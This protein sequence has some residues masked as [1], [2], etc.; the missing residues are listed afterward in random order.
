MLVAA[1]A[2]TAALA[3]GAA[4]AF[5]GGRVESPSSSGVP[6]AVGPVAASGLP[7]GAGDPRA[8]APSGA[9]ASASSAPATPRPT[10]PAV[11]LPALLGAIGD[12]LTAAVNVTGVLAT[13]PEHSWVLGSAPDDEVTSHL[14]RLRTLGSDPVVVPAARPGAPIAAAVRQANAIVERAAELEDGATAYVTFELG[15]NDICADSLDET[16]DPATFRAATRTALELLRDGLPAG[17]HV[18]V[19]SVPD[20]TRLRAVIEEVPLAQALHRRYDVCR[21][22]LGEEADTDAVRT[23]IEAYNDALTRECEALADSDVGCR[24]DLGGDPSRS[25]FGAEF[26]LPDLSP[27][28]YFHPS[29]AGQA[30]IADE[31]W[32]LTPW[33]A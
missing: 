19:L 7:S 14:E 9:Q 16:T 12:S 30:R 28:D 6:A 2:A 3:L 5:A 29:L 25:L 15:A 32:T 22:V 31:T 24:H 26:S 23:R 13:E 21:S 33:G 27:L 4:L 8:P 11:Q 10:P 20:V 1:V 18:L 17:S